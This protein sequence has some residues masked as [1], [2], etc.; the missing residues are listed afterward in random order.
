MKTTKNDLV[1]ALVALLLLAWP[2]PSQSQDL[3]TA[4]LGTCQLESGENLRPCNIAYRTMGSLNAQRDNAVLVPTWFT[5]TSEESAGFFAT[6]VDTTSFYVVVVDA[7][8]NGVST[9]PSN[10]PT[11]GGEAFPTISIGDMVTTQYRLVTE[12]LGL[13]GLHGVTGASMGGMQTFEWM[14]SHP[15]FF[16]KAMP[17]IGSPKLG[18][19]DIAL[20]ET[21][22]RILDLYETCQCSDA[23]AVLAGV[24]M[25]AGSSPEAFH[26]QTD[27]ADV[28]TSLESAA[29]ATLGRPAGWTHD[30][31]SQLDAMIRHDV[32]RHHGRDMATAA[33]STE[34]DLLSVVVGTDHVVTPWPAIEFAELAGGESIVLDNA[35]GHGG[36]FVLGAEYVNQ[37]RAF[38][39][40]ND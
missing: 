28:E 13:A 24:G 31:A 17:L 27:P 30:M 16:K 22:L 18:P 10:S 34:A 5:G 20:W 11:Q 4:E 15:R 19:Y 7:L 38:L 35:G 2:V 23:A 29:Q 3:R 37:V 26:A 9:S 40:R 8:G 36:L 25:L 12:E 33:A 1:P 39:A 21:E 14:V 32:S 6:L